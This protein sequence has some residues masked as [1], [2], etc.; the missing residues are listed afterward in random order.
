MQA[1]VIMSAK[2]QSSINSFF[3]QLSALTKG[4]LSVDQ[5]IRGSAKTIGHMLEAS[6]YYSP[7]D[8]KAAQAVFLLCVP[9]LIAEVGTAVLEMPSARMQLMSADYVTAVSQLGGELTLNR[10]MELTGSLLP[11]LLEEVD[12]RLAAQR[13]EQFRSSLIAAT[14]RSAR[15]PLGDHNGR[16][17]RGRSEICWV[18]DGKRCPRERDGGRCK[19]AEFGHPRGKVAEQFKGRRG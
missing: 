3:Q 17:G 2:M 15:A 14:A 6:Q 1:A 7:A 5:L 13:E 8:A 4:K 11:R 12:N 19:F 9:D 10:S 18:W 16:D